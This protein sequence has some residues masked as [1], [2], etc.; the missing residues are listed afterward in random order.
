MP[1]FSANH[2]AITLRHF[3]Y[4]GK[5]SIRM[6][7]DRESLGLKTVFTSNSFASYRKSSFERI[8][9]FKDGLIFGEDT[10]AAGQFLLGG[11]KIAYVAD[12]IVYHSHN[13]NPVEEFKRY[14]DIGVLH[15][16]EKWLLETFGSAEGQGMKY[17]KHEINFLQKKKYFDL[18][19]ELCIRVLLK[20]FGYKMGRNYKVLPKR[21][22]QC[23][24]M[25]NSWWIDRS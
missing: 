18:L 19:P 12:A 11:E 14:F 6:L 16:S 22:I 3:N 25:H 8:G 9:Y 5:S 10:I 15:T 2:F 20:Y 23:L 1:D 13:Y 24:S 17:I 4:P 7:N 21:I